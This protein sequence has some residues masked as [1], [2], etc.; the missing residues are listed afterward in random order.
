MQKYTNLFQDTLGRIIPNATVTVTVN[1][2]GAAATL[3]SDNGVTQ[4]PSNTT[5]TDTL[6][7]FYFYAANGRY[8]IALSKTGF[9]TET[10]T[11]VLL[12]DPA[13]PMANAVTDFGAV[14]DGV[15]DDTTALQNWL[16]Y[17]Q[18]RPLYL[19]KGIYKITSKLTTTGGSTIFGAGQ[20]QSIIKKF[21]NGD[22]IDWAAYVAFVD[23]GFAGNGATYTGSIATISAGNSQ[24]MLRTR[25]TDSQSNPVKWTVADIGTQ[26]EFAQ[27]QVW[28]TTLTNAAFLFNAADTSTFTKGTM[29]GIDCEGGVLFDTSTGVPS[30][31]VIGCTTT[32]MVFND[33][34]VNINV[35]GCRIAGDVHVKGNGVVIMDCTISGDVYLD[36]NANGCTIGPNAYASGH[37]LI[38]N[39]AAPGNMT[40]D[41]FKTATWT[42]VLTNSIPGDLAVGYLRQLGTKKRCGRQVTLT[43]AVVTN[44]FTWTTAAGTWQ[45]TG[46]PY[47]SDTLTGFAW[48]GSLVFQGIT[49]ANFTNFNSTITSGSSVIVIS[50][51]GSAQTQGSLAAADM[52]TG[53][54]VILRFTITYD[55]P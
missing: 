12:Y 3:Y 24:A 27:S 7:E 26:F 14:G 17:G 39:S 47:A 4:L 6:G 13:T 54:T 46:Q 5:T 34:N 15:T 22:M 50:C 21:F 30:F 31:R 29:I 18:Y 10:L 2:T 41:D 35:S 55:T 48:E 28:S 11:D 8:D 40:W 42:P 36:L 53:G 20:N 25:M 16:N 37:G 44:A 51:S 32:G 23:M 9:T 52:P 19:P 38:D 45:I 1:S 33:N 49:K 43:C